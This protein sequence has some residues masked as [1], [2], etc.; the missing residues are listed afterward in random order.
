MND[1][2]ARNRKSGKLEIDVPLLRDR[3]FVLDYM[4]KSDFHITRQLTETHPKY[5]LIL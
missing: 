5:S 2:A 1:L 4:S 3:L